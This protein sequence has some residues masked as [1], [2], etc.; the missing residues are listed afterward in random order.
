MANKP[1]VTHGKIFEQHIKKAMQGMENRFPIRFSK[2]VDSFTAGNLI[3]AVDSDFKLQIKGPLQGTPYVIYIEAKATVTDKDFS[4]NYRDFVKSGQNA[5][6]VMNV[7][8]GAIGCY[9]FH[10]V[11]EGVFEV[12]DSTLVSK[13][14]PHLRT[15]IDGHAAFTIALSNLPQ[16]MLGICTNPSHFLQGLRSTQQ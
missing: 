8:A 16:F 11:N 5:A 7:R 1:D 15:A 10:K 12:W 3:Q 14:F 2:T 4:R 6:M 9:F 13:V